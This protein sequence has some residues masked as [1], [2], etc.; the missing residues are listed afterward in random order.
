VQGPD[1]HPELLA[2]ARRLWRVAGP[3][4]EGAV[5]LAGEV[6]NLLIDMPAATLTGVL[7]QARLLQH[8]ASC[9]PVDYG[10]ITRAVTAVVAGLERLAGGTRDD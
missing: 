10:A 2:E 8:Y 1:P 4:S 6:E 7:A 9:D 3:E 5:R